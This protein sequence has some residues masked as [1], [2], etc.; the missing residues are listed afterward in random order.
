MVCYWVL[1]GNGYFLPWLLWPPFLPASE[2]FSRSLLE[3][4][5]DDLPP[6]WP[7]SD[8]FFLSS[9]KFPDLE[10]PLLGILISSRVSGAPVAS[11]SCD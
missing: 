4:P 2:V 6:F 1:S 10:F 7:A 3:P 8:A 5:L 11:P 9:A